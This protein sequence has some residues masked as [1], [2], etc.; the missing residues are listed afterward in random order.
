MSPSRLDPAQIPEVL[1]A[2]QVKSALNGFDPTVV[3]T[4][5]LRIHTTQSDLDV[6]CE[7]DNSEEF[8][9][10]LHHHTE[11][12]RDSTSNGGSCSEAQAW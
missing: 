12:I 11:T 6:V 1:E 7:V 5:P 2:L 9:R 4:I 8:E 3:G 10:M